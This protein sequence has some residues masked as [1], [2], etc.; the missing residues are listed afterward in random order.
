MIAA[1]PRLFNWASR[2]QKIVQALQVTSVKSLQTIE[3]NG[4][5][6]YPPPPS[7]D[8]ATAR[9]KAGSD[10]SG[11]FSPSAAAQTLGEIFFAVWSC[12]VSLRVRWLPVCVSLY[13]KRVVKAGMASDRTIKARA[14]AISIA[15]YPD[16][17][18]ASIFGLE[19]RR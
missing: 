16:G 15:G 3:I 19:I 6:F 1:K 12:V 17:V 10:R 11:L 5:Y 9:T 8:R 14:T 13:A 7:S 4:F 2:H 18:N